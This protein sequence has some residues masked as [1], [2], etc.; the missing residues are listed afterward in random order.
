[1]TNYVREQATGRMQARALVTGRPM[2]VDFNEGASEVMVERS[3]VSA[4]RTLTIGEIIARHQQQQRAQDAV[5]KSY[6]AHARSEQHFRPTIADPGYDVVTEN[7]Y[8][9]AGSEVEWEELSFSVSRAKFGPDRPSFAV[10]AGEGA[11]AAAPVRRRLS[12]PARRQRTVDGTVLCRPLR[13]V[14]EDGSVQSTVWIDKKTFARVRVQAVQGG[15]SAP[16][17]SNDETQRY[18]PVVVGNRPV[19]LFSGLTARQS[20]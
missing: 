17:V 3:G 19:F 6:T 7:R 2:V 1:M 16:V 12:I 11:L 4:V 20:C 18:S 5:V 15:L 9:V 10:A 8:F 13:P 14:R